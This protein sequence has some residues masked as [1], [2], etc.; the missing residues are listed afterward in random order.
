MARN[1]MSLCTLTFIV[2]GRRE[3]LRKR[4]KDC[5][6]CLGFDTDAGFEPRVPAHAASLSVL[7][8]RGA[9]SSAAVG[10][11]GWQRWSQQDCG[12][13]R[14]WRRRGPSWPVPQKPEDN[15]PRWRSWD[16]RASGEAPAPGSS[17]G[18]YLQRRIPVPTLGVPEQDR[19]GNHPPGAS[20][21]WDPAPCPA[22]GVQC[23]PGGSRPP[24]TAPSWQGAGGQ[25]PLPH[26]G[27]GGTTCCATACSSVTNGA[28][29][30]EA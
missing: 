20:L 15:K 3:I 28:I 18:E 17:S 26:R 2:W 24:R 25:E 7:S 23:Q 9:V 27:L 10:G 6:Q 19:V 8:S 29:R 21:M 14:G 13:E 5:Q 22:H 12:T 11:W 16:W 4:D 30:A 1:Q